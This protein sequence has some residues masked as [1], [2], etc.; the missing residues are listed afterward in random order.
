[1]DKETL[2]QITATVNQEINAVQA[3][4]LLLSELLVNLTREGDI[5]SDILR[6]VI[7]GAG[8]GYDLSAVRKGFSNAYLQV[9]EQDPA[10]APSGEKFVQD[11]GN[12]VWIQDDAGKITSY[13]KGQ[14]NLGL[15]RRPNITTG[16]WRSIFT[17][18]HSSLTPDGVIVC[19][20][21][22]PDL[23]MKGLDPII[24]ENDLTY[25]YF[26]I[27]QHNGLPQTDK[28]LILMR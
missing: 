25:Q 21:A 12:A 10:F 9:I 6:I 4:I 17:A 19:T 3:D 1:M 14:Y 22:E 28:A 11:V 7:A 20:L 18:M 15:V 2:R 13:G 8:M 23:E 27:P 16:N 26:D 5:P 24:A